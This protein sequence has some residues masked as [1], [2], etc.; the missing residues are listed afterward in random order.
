MGNLIFTICW[1]ISIILVIYPD[2]KIIFTK[3][4][5]NGDLNKKYDTNYSNITDD[6]DSI[7]N[8]LDLAYEYRY[9][10]K[11]LTQVEKLNKNL[12][13]ISGVI[14]R[15]DNY[16]DNSEDDNIKA[17]I[18]EIFESMHS[19]IRPMLK[20]SYEMVENDVETLKL[21]VKLSKEILDF[22]IQRFELLTLASS[23]DVLTQIENLK[24][25]NSLS[26]QE[27]ESLKELNSEN[28]NKTDNLIQLEEKYCSSDK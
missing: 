12:G 26:K 18:S 16:A 19:T 6:I 21:L 8:N 22:A 1:A 3:K 24:Q 13:K 11:A 25:F 10:G 15:L 27:L 9:K 4:I 2:I 7:S 5:P 20:Y 17:T 14:T 23:S 28:S